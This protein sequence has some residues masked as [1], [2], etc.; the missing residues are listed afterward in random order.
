MNISKVLIIGYVWPETNASAAATR[1]MALLEQFRSAGWEVHYASPAK[2]GPFSG[3]LEAMG[4]PTFSCEANDPRFDAFIR[5]LCPDLVVFDR[6]VIEEQFGWRVEENAPNAIRVL[7]LQDLHFLR[8]ARGAALQ[9]GWTLDRIHEASDGM[10][11]QFGG[12]DL[13]REL[14]SI[15][16]SDLTLVISSFELQLLKQRYQIPSELL[17]LQRFS[18]TPLPQGLLPSFE[19]RKH[20]VSIGNFRHPPNADAVLWLE[21]EIWP[22]I[23]KKIPEAELHV[24][25]AYPPREM[26]SLSNPANG[27]IVKGQAVDQYETLKRYRVLLAPLRFGAGI[28]GKIADAWCTETAV[29]SSPIGAEG[30]IDGDQVQWPG[31]IADTTR[32]FVDGSFDL[33]NN[34]DLWA[35]RTQAGRLAISRFYNPGLNSRILTGALRSLQDELGE[36]RKKNRV[37]AILRHS[38]HRSTKY[39]SKWIELK[40]SKATEKKAE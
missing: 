12:E 38:L 2:P 17:L 4:I 36:R 3:K 14:S 6:F 5:E 39:F 35:E 24:Y 20:F 11:E 19:D 34:Y 31:E 15:Y 7:D 23:R 21:R 13:L 37:G 9:A 27:F 22:A 8:R 1:D 10:I 25:G 28:K 32:A 40:N 26:M 33:Y 30:M 29:V 16:R 18:L